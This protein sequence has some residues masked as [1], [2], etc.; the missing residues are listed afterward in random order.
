LRTEINELFSVLHP[1]EP[2]NPKKPKVNSPIS[3]SGLAHAQVPN[4]NEP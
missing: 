4:P 1:K 3:K 2:K